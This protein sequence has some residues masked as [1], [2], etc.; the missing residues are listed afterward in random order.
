M[1]QRER[2]GDNLLVIELPLHIFSMQVNVYPSD[3]SGPS[4]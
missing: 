4:L 3:I 1:R 2:E